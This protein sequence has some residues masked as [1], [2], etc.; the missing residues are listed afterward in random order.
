[1]TYATIVLALFLQNTTGSL[2][3]DSAPNVFLHR[4]LAQQ[5]TRSDLEFLG[6]T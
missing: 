1:M 3:S 5:S 4:V 2:F 6:W